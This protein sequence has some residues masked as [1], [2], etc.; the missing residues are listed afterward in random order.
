MINNNAIGKHKNIR[1]AKTF[2][3]SQLKAMI[4]KVIKE[5]IDFDNDE[6]K[7]IGKSIQNARLKAIKYE[8]LAR[9]LIKLAENEDP[10]IAR[11]VLR[12]QRDLLDPSDIAA[13]KRVLKK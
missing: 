9:I 7:D 6:W 12:N 1:R 10:M 11:A 2:T 5:Q 8:G 3:K 4:Q 13:L